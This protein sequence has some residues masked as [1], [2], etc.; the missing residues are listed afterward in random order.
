MPDR[1]PGS[2]QQATTRPSNHAD[3]TCAACGRTITWRKKWER[4]WDNVKFCSDN[5]RAHKPKARD[6]AMEETILRL[7][8]D[9]G[10]GKTICPSEA[11]RTV[12]GNGTLSDDRTAWDPLMDPARAAA[13]RLA[14][15]GT[16]VITQGGHT[17]DPS[18]AKGAIR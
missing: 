10:A 16:I 9:R 2:S 17:V 1:T 11:A 7:L 5:C 3:K 4:D 8:H 15:A 6:A 14:A 18:T 12:A 13:R